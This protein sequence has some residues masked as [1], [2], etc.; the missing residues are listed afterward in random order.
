[1]PHDETARRARLCETILQYLRRHPL[2][3]D[4][5][6]GIVACWLPRTGFEDAPD[7]IDAALRHMLAERRLAVRRLPDGRVLYARG[8]LLDA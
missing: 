2:A 1:M 6:D 3:A 5:A 7:H 4:T 8:E